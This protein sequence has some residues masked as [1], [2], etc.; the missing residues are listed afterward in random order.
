MTADVRT[1]AAGGAAASIVERFIEEY[2]E[3]LEEQ[4]LLPRLEHVRELG[5]YEL[6]RFTPP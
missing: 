5:I 6:S 1:T 2:H 4:Y 3:Q